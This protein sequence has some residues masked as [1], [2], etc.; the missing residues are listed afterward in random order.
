MKNLTQTYSALNLHLTQ[1][2]LHPYK[3]TF[4]VNN[5]HELMGAYIW[6]QQVAA[7][8]YPLFHFIEIF[9]RNA[10]DKAAKKRFGDYW[11]DTFEYDHTDT[12]CEKFI[13][14][15]KRAKRSLKNNWEIAERERLGLDF[16]D[17]IPTPIPTFSHDQI[18]AATEFST[19]TFILTNGFFKPSNSSSSKYLWPSS[20][21]SAFPQYNKVSSSPLDALKHMH[22]YLTDI[23]KYRNRVF[24]HEPIWTKGSTHKLTS[25]RAI[26]TIRQKITKMEYFLELMGKRLHKEFMATNLINHSKRICSLQ[27]LYMY[28]NKGKY[29]QFTTKQK[30]L[31]RKKLSIAQQETVFISYNEKVFGLTHII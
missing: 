8:M 17:P 14:N 24:H 23:R 26:Q 1:S 28:Q 22:D 25:I 9:A 7:T 15:I 6:S 18:I 11:W 27:E 13:G 29:V 30:R 5:D 3:L 2:R 16:D 31:L 4:D 19:W 10:I 20:L 12:S 21:G